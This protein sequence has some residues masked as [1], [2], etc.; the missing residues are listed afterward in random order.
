MIL[1]NFAHPLHPSVVQALGGT[2]ITVVTCPVNLDMSQDFVPQIKAIISDMSKKLKIEHSLEADRVLVNLPGLATAAALILAEL[3]GRIGHF[4][5]IIRLKQ[6][7]GIF[8]LAETVDLQ[9]VR[10]Q[11]RTTRFE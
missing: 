5:E 3:H 2:G 6:N 10:N 7:E 9:T 11:A 1:L 8:V 4:P